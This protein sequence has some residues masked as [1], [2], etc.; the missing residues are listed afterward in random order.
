MKKSIAGFRGISIHSEYAKNFE[1]K[2]VLALIQNRTLNRG[3]MSMFNYY[4]DLIPHGKRAKY[5]IINNIKQ[6]DFNNVMEW[7]KMKHLI[8]KREF[9]KERYENINI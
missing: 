5:E 4:I 6:K 1:E 8:I 9:S 7:A 2:R 3:L